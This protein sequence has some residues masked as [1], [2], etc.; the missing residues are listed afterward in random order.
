MAAG[1]VATISA[2]SVAPAMM[3]SAENLEAGLFM[4]L[5]RGHRT[6]GRRRAWQLSWIPVVEVNVDDP[7]STAGARLG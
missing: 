1:A 2:M 4:M 6:R 3:L 7:V 5:R